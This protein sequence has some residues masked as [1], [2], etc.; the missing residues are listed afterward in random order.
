MVYNSLIVSAITLLGLSSTLLDGVQAVPT[1]NAANQLF[2]KIYRSH[3]IYSR[4][5]FLDDNNL[6]ATLA[7]STYNEEDLH[8]PVDLNNNTLDAFNH[9][10]GIFFGDYA[11]HFSGKDMDG[12]LAVGRDFA[13]ANFTINALANANDICN[14]IENS[15]STNST[16]MFK[17]YGFVVQGAPT[18]FNVS[19]NGNV[20]LGSGTTTGISSCQPCEDHFNDGIGNLNFTLLQEIATN[21]SY[22]LANQNPTMKLDVEGSLTTV[23]YSSMN[24][25]NATITPSFTSLKFDSCS[26]KGKCGAHEDE[27]SDP[28]AIFFNNGT[29][30]GAEYPTDKPIVFNIPVTTGT[31]LVIN[32]PNPGM[33]L[34]A[35][36]T[37][38]HAYAVDG[39]GEFL[40]NGS[41]TINRETQEYL[42][43]LFFAP[44]A[45]IMDGKHGGFE[46][47]VIALG[48]TWGSEDGPALK[49]YNTT[50]CMAEREC[51][52]FKVGNESV[53]IPTATVTS[54]VLPTATA[55]ISTVLV[56][57]SSILSSAS[58][59]LTAQ[60]VEPSTTDIILS[61]YSTATTGVVASST[62]WVPIPIETTTTMTDSS[63]TTTTTYGTESTTT[64]TDDS[65]IYLTT[66]TVYETQS[67]TRTSSTDDYDDYSSSSTTTTSTRTDD[68]YT[69]TTTTTD[70]FHYTPI[71]T[72][73][74]STTDSSTT[75]YYHEI[76]MATPLGTQSSSSTDETTSTESS[77]TRTH[78]RRPPRVTTVFTHTDIHHDGTTTKIETKTVTKTKTVYATID[79]Q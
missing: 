79:D 30:D 43:G 41:F 65:T 58:N 52:P 74:S 60:E 18:A 57:S 64:T 47:Q 66:T 14:T 22:Y 29:W 34:T 32:T 27:V 71:T 2:G 45:T 19:V 17:S 63:S 42:P 21:V 50:E 56:A 77:S 26:L 12:P 16:N 61:D 5:I 33:N 76:T 8:C 78:S 62:I 3:R 25:T 6:N 49:T 37:V 46:G 44:R 70:H 28:S 23:D 75:N 73:R 40:A 35:C 1:V 9:F 38:F 48:Y 10:Q 72:T 4:D 31:T 68:D 11:V 53:I 13:G 7:N 39:N 69:T 54:T 36:G 24:I 20:Y 55:F 51:F 67:R 59:V 15:D